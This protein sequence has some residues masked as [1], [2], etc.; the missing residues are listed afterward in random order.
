MTAANRIA[1]LLRQYP[2]T[3][4]ADTSL[5]HA[6]RSR[7]LLW[8]YQHVK[9]IL[10]QAIGVEMPRAYA[11]AGGGRSERRNDLRGSGDGQPVMQPV[12]VRQRQHRLLTL[13]RGWPGLDIGG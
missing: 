2:G 3:G 12:R 13:A 5:W 1:Q 10:L 7:G 9:P 8:H 6:R 4:H 11:R